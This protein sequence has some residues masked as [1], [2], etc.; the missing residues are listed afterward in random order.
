MLGQRFET[1]FIDL[2]SRW[3]AWWRAPRDPDRVVE[4]ASARMLLDDA[5]GA[6]ALERVRLDRPPGIEG[7]RTSVSAEDRARLAVR[8]VGYV[9]G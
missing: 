9:Q 4:L 1:L 3:E 2:L 6:I 5:R 7:S 8:G